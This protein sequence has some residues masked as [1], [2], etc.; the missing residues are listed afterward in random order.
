MA[1]KE[2]KIRRGEVILEIGFGTGNTLIKIAEYIGKN[3]VVHGIKYLSQ[4]V[5]TG[6]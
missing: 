4:N 6:E 2:L 3:G 5:R 1:L